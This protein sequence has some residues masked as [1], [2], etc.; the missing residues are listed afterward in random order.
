MKNQKYYTVKPEIKPIAIPE[1][2]VILPVEQLYVVAVDDM[3]LKSFVPYTL[4]ASKYVAQHLSWN[5]ADSYA[6][7]IKCCKRKTT[8]VVAV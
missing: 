2:E 4:T 7:Y 5:D 8:E 6:A 3:W 1:P